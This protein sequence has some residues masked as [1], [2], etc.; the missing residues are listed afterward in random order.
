MDHPIFKSIDAGDLEDVETLISE[1]S[2][3][4]HLVDFK[5]WTPLHHAVI[6]GHYEIANF[7]IQQGAIVSVLTNDNRTPL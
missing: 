7:L 1:N 5:N 4:I 3:C 6:R 2:S